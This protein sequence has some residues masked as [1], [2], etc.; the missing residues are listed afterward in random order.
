[1][2][3]Y[4]VYSDDCGEWDF[5]VELFL[6]GVFYT[7]EEADKCINDIE[8]ED[9]TPILYTVEVEVGEKTHEFL[10]GNIG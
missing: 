2:K 9:I 6:R 10:G 5:N 4:I 3:V 1:M 8:S 7:K